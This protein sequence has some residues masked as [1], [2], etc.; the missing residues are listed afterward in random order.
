MLIYCPRMKLAST[1][2][3]ITI[4]L[5]GLPRTIALSYTVEYYELYNILEESLTSV[6]N[7]SND[8]VSNLKKLRETFFPKRSSEPM[9]VGVEYV[10][11]NN[12]LTECTTDNSSFLWTKSQVGASVATLLLAYHR[13]IGLKGFEW[14]RSCLVD[15][16]MEMRLEIPE[17]TACNG[18]LLEECLADLT[19]QVHVAGFC[20]SCCGTIVL[21]LSIV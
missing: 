5:V 3:A 8:T 4:C 2:C 20:Y 15:S 18:S 17:G 14:D 21:S 12:E 13:G 11:T 9:C 6:S 19:T 1:L 16:K 10:F 7:Q